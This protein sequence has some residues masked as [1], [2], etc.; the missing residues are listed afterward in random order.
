[1]PGKSG[2]SASELA[3]NYGVSLNE[4]A[5]QVMRLLA[6]AEA[7]PPAV[8]AAACRREVCAAVS[9]AMTFALDASRLT[10]EERTVLDPLLR[11]VLIP[12]W[13]KHCAADGSVAEYITSRADFYLT[14]RVAGSQVKT[15][16]SIVT[17]LVEALE[18]PAERRAEL[19][20]ALAPSFAHRMVAD[21]FRLNEVR[22]RYGLQLSLLGALGMLLQVSLSHD[23]ILRILRIS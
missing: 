15:A 1:M 4:F 3:R 22:G 19:V 11:E 16:V 18:F 10:P 21:V 13:N 9:A 20:Q 7:D 2:I 17:L 6:R 14:R 5:D 12:F 8:R 23:A